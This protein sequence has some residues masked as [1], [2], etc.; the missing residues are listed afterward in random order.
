[1]YSARQHQHQHTVLQSV[2]TRITHLIWFFS[3]VGLRLFTTAKL[4]HVILQ[5]P[6]HT[7]PPQ[8]LPTQ[9]HHNKKWTMLWASEKPKKQH[10]CTRTHT[11]VKSRGRKG[12]NKRRTVG[13]ASNPSMSAQ[14]FALITWQPFTNDT[15]EKQRL[16]RLNSC[17]HH[18]TPQKTKQE[19]RGCCTQCSKAGTDS[20]ASQENKKTGQ[21]CAVLFLY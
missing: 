15:D 9:T 16:L 4:C 14:R 1:M 5:T 21:F 13:K 17:L 12:L 19:W 6:R 8:P 11:S 10:T 2:N 18:S 3:Y 20:T 7:P